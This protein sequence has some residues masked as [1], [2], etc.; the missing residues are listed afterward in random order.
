MSERSGGFE[1]TLGRGV[2]AALALG[3]LTA[4]CGA[5]LP[6]EAPTPPV[7]PLVWPRHPAEP[8][9]RY[10]RTITGLRDAGIGKSFFPG[11]VESLLGKTDEY[12]IRPTGVVE[13]DGVLYVA[14]PGAQA[15][16]I[17]DTPGRR[18]VKVQRIAGTELAAP[19][20]VALGPNGAVF[21]ADSW[22]QKIFL[23]D[24]A[25][26]LVRIVVGEGLE[27]PAGLAYDAASDRLYVADSAGHRI[28]V[29]AADGRRRDTWGTRGHGDGEF[30]YP[31][32]VALDRTGTVLVT[33]ALNYRIEAFDREGRFLWKLG[34]RGDGSG[35][36]AAPKGVALDSAGHLYIVDALFDAVQIFERRG[37]FLLSF[38]ERG[39]HPG[40]FWLPGGISISGQ[41]RI[42]VADSYNQRVQVFDYL[43]GPR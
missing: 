39:V 18:L 21:V 30:N 8:R 15:V 16:W 31:T 34:R 1:A 43:G 5:H 6:A 37:A 25:G 13:R 7:A 38:G 42:Y 2:L 19:V 22:L 27:R 33:D 36:L 3:L 32:H 24:R 9:I 28:G 26:K 40:Q 17:F 20:A 10:V 29:Y 23:L 11:L 35:D 41:D 14:D 12:L 4:A